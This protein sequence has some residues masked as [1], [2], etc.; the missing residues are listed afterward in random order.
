MNVVAQQHRRPE[1]PY[2]ATA[3]VLLFTTQQGHWR[4]CHNMSYPTLVAAMQGSWR[5][6][7]MLPASA[8]QDGDDLEFHTPASKHRST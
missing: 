1:Q 2:T 4:L 8:H 6:R 5:K 3:T 7:Q